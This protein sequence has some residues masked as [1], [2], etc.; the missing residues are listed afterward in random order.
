MTLLAS[1][2][3]LLHR[4]GGNQDISLGTPVAGRNQAEIEGL[5]GFFVNTL[6]LRTTLSGWMS[7]REL[8]KRVREAALGAYAHQDL[9]FE[10]LVEEL[11]PERMLNRTPLFQV[12][13]AFQHAPRQ[14]WRLPGIHI[15]REEIQSQTS[16]F[17]LTLFLTETERN[18]Q[19]TFEYSTDLFDL[20]VIQ[21]MAEHF[22]TMLGGIIAN[23]EI[24]V[25]ELPLL[26]PSEYEQVIVQWNGTCRDYPH[27]C[28]LAELFQLQVEKTPEALA[29]TFED[30]QLTYRELN[31]RANQVAHYLRSKGIGPEVLVGICMERSLQMVIGLLGILKAGGAYVPFDPEYPQDRLVYMIQDSGVALV[32]TQRD[33]AVSPECAESICLDRQWDEISRESPD[34][35]ISSVAPENL[36]YVIYTSGSTGAP[37]GVANEHRSVVNYLCWLQE[38]YPLLGS[39][40]I[41]QKTPYTFDVSIPEF[42]WTLMTGASLVISRPAGHQ[43]PD[44]M[45]D[46]IVAQK[47]TTI[48]FVPSMLKAFLEN[49]GVERCTS[50]KKVICSGEALPESAQEHFFQRLTSAELINAYGPTEAA[51]EVTHWQC[52]A[53]NTT[54]PI[55]H[56]APNVQLYILDQYLQPVPAGMSG[57]L[58][59]AG[60]QVARGYVNR[61]DFTAEKFVPNPFSS[62]PGQRM[63]RTGDL[64]R[65]NPDGSVEFLGRLDYQV[66]LR[67]FRIEL[68]EIETVLMQYPA[69]LEA[70]VVMRE[71]EDGEKRLVA[72]V[73]NREGHSKPTVS[74]LRTHLQGKL[75]DYMIPSAFVRLESLPRTPNGKI[76]RKSLPR[77]DITIVTTTYVPPRTPV[78]GM[79]A[80]IWSQVLNVPRIGIHDNFFELGG[81]SLLAIRIIS[82]IRDTFQAEIHLKGLF[83]GPTIAKL[84]QIIDREQESEESYSD[85]M[86]RIP[87]SAELPLSYNQEA[88]LLREWFSQIRDVRQT[89]FHVV[90]GFDW[91]GAFDVQLLEGAINLVIRR[92][93]ILRTSFIPLKER[94]SLELLSILDP[95]VRRHG[96]QRAMHKLL[97]VA[98]RFFKQTLCPSASLKLTIND[99]QHLSKEGQ[100]SEIA[101]VVSREIQNRFDYEK[102]PLMRMAVLRMG[103]Q[104]HRLIITVHHL[105]SDFW[106][107]EILIRELSI[108]YQRLATGNVAPLP[109][110]PIQYSDFAAWQR[111]RLQG[112]RM[113]MLAA[114]WRKQ[115]MNIGLLDVKELGFHKIQSAVC[116]TAAESLSFDPALCN[117]V[118]EFVC[119]RGVTTYML[120][121]AGLYSLLHLHSGKRKIGIW[122]SFAN[123]TRTET[124]NLIGWFANIHL[125]GIELDPEMSADRLLEEVRN[126]VLEAHAQQEIPFSLLWATA[127]QDLNVQPHADDQNPSPFVMFDF[128]PRAQ[129]IDTVNGPQIRQVSLPVQPIQVAIHF[130]AWDEND[131]MG[132]S[133]HYATQAFSAAAIGQ[134]LA[135]LERVLD[136]LISA[137]DTP[138]AGFSSSLHSQV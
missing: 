132:I 125:L 129:N 3:A 75:P 77:P 47:I 109:D 67:G 94:A 85:A 81:H 32:L 26:T 111:N 50:L 115:W 53:R 54:V 126:R 105:A 113:A 39:D 101:D 68:G 38:L 37:K 8:L 96:M 92:H 24:P 30:Q 49:Q 112:R 41:M 99:I 33:V 121:L 21:R 91:I 62:A 87:A 19:A 136:I 80:G 93:Q 108:S 133:A 40:R 11:R 64:V 134:L 46:L 117:R 17:D 44:Y 61:P 4:Y 90:L 27:D 70:V 104:Q 35:P 13:F 114:Y 72:Y 43:D 28:S 23:P 52:S 76:D 71:S 5:I 74:S 97:E 14:E 82:R 123:R 65:W 131:G 118:K 2:K 12:M 55:G 119:H 57:E 124:E 31:Q 45:V 60:A 58:F 106:S 130:L 29:V 15:K 34:N 116:S 102:P 10:K 6:V 36:A 138:V 22:R 89:P 88:R 16:K 137:P 79:L 42:F 51:V 25:A 122:G 9:P 18:L 95:V 120:F 20:A 84:T 1:F 78:E 63:Y 100:A 59:I 73:T 135:D 98:P 110:L 48:R 69:V 66:K 7:F 86:T 107:M 103:P 127:L 83:A 56:P 128:H